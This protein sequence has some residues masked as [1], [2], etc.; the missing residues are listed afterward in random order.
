MSEPRLRRV[1]VML[2][3]AVI[4]T[5]EAELAARHVAQA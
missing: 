2:S 5:I 3:P 1:D 4:D